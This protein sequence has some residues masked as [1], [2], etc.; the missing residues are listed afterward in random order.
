[1]NIIIESII[2]V[3]IVVSGGR[4]TLICGAHLHRVGVAQ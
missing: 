4:D 2:I 1:M 3:I